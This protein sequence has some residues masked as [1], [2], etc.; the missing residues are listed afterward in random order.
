[1]SPS[2]KMSLE[3]IMNILSLLFL[4]LGFLQVFHKWSV[5]GDDNVKQFIALPLIGVV[6][7]VAFT[8]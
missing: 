4:A 2:K 7:W 1:M 3:I 6:V 5:L 8:S